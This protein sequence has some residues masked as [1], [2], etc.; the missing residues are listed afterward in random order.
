MRTVSVTTTRT[1]AA[2]TELMDNAI[3]V[4]QPDIPPFLVVI[5]RAEF[6]KMDIAIMKALNAEAEV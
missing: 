2:G 4:D 5:I 1:T 3:P 6:T